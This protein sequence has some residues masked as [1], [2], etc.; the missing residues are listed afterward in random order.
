MFPRGEMGTVY[1]RSLHYCLQLSESTM[2][3]IN[4]LMQKTFN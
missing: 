4:V 1:K 3:S 2:N